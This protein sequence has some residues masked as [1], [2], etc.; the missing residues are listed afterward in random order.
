M[1][2]IIWV[3][4][5]NKMQ[6]QICNFTNK[7]AKKLKKIKNCNFVFFNA[8]IHTQLRRCLITQEHQDWLDQ[9]FLI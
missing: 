6:T 2:R 1:Q 5:F 7:I 3:C 8:L 9:H 4:S